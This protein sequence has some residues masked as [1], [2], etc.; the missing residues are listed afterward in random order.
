MSGHGKS[1]FKRV[2]AKWPWFKFALVIIVVFIV[3]TMF[4]TLRNKTGDVEYA[5]REI[6][7]PMQKHVRIVKDLTGKKLVAL[8]FDD[9]P[10]AETTPRL[11]DI[12]SEKD[13]KATFFELGK[14]ARANVEI[15]KR[16]AEEGHEIGSH[17]MYH[18]NLGKATAGTIR[19]D[20]GEANAVFQGIL[21]YVPSLM[22]PPY[23]STNAALKSNVGAPMILWTVDTMDWKY[24][25][26]ESILSYTTSEVFDG[27][28]ILMH[29]IHATTVDAV[30]VVIDTLRG[31]GYEFL[32][33]SEL[34]KIRG[35]ELKNGV[36]Y[37]SLK[38]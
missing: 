29:D 10:G 7:A 21:G 23:G 17:T 24:K 3:G 9:G 5:G 27:A 15:V 35:I 11:L 18:Q 8:T 16:V 36:S 14:M 19:S 20:I 4:L 22:R 32:T 26:T 28:I 30:P 1:F 25:N 12:L 38:P 2:N 6:T 31:M 34:A 13:V 37:G 33:V